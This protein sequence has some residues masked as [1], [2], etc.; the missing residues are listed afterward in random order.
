MAFSI[1][2]RSQCPRESCASPDRLRVPILS[3]KLQ[4][5]TGSGLLDCGEW[6]RKEKIGD[7]GW[8]QELCVPG[9]LLCVP[10]GLVSPKV[11]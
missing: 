11:W 3:S 7:L 9:F 5:P 4:G 2:L 10:E 1:A 8:P 6:G